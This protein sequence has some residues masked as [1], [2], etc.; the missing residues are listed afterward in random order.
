MDNKNAIFLTHP[1]FLK[2]RVTGGVQLCS[3]EFYLVLKEAKFKLIEYNVDYTKNLF[4][5]LLIKLNFN[6]YKVFSIKKDKQKLL[7][8]IEKNNVKWVFIN[9]AT[10]VRYAP[11]IKNKFG[12]KV[13][14][15]LLSHGNYS[16][17]FLHLTTK[18]IKKP[19]FFSKFIDIVKLGYLIHTESLHRVKFIDIVLTVSDIETQIENWFGAKK[20]IFIP[21]LLNEFKLK[22]KTNYRRVGFVGR[23]DHPPNYQ[24]ITLLL[25]ELK[26]IKQ[27]DYLIR[28]VG[29]PES[30][31]KKIEKKYDFVEY[32]GELSDKDLDT[33][34]ATWALFLNT[35]F[36]YSTGVTTKL[37]W[38]IN[39]GLPIVTTTPGMRGYKWKNGNL[40]IKET[41]YEMADFINNYILD[42]ENIENLK[43]EIIKIRNSSYSA[44]D[45]AKN[46]LNELDIV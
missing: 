35:V 5:R 20:T 7:D 23:L 21:R 18:P 17:D 26:K 13:K 9:M 41:P 28:I 30:W 2:S 16:G 6:I 14:I 43:K 3:Q 31:G 15:V 45:I 29:A 10:L 37:A 1:I 8:Y 46:I 39:R 42:K 22:L 27:N 40:P 4:D 34:V 12:S 44:N 32:T 25:D 33:E 38:A 19:N 11:I 36:W 24:G